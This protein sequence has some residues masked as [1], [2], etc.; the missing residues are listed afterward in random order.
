M[1]S[2]IAKPGQTAHQPGH[3]DVHRRQPSTTV[4]QKKGKKRM[5][6]A[7]IGDR[8]CALSNRVA[9]GGIDAPEPSMPLNEGTGNIASVTRF[10]RGQ[11]SAGFARDSVRFTWCP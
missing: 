3:Q 11:K 5:I 9:S 2:R 8:Q 4:R 1:G 7:R 10:E 6:H